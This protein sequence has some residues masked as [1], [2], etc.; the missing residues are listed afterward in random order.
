MGAPRASA[1][2][3]RHSLNFFS[4]YDK[5]NIFLFHIG[6]TNAATSGCV[7][8]TLSSV[9]SIKSKLRSRIIVMN[10]VKQTRLDVH[11]QTFSQ[12][13]FNWSVEE[14]PHFKQTF[15]GY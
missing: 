14:L 10:S 2:S 13:V 3:N 12:T 9:S 8:Q 7:N 1:P 5:N 11:Y 6:I 15:V 4:A